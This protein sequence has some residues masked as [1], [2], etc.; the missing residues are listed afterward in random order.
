MANKSIK[1][2]K[3]VNDNFTLIKKL[4]LQNNVNE[5]EVNGLL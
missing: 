5:L 2:P 4:A 3:H 1:F